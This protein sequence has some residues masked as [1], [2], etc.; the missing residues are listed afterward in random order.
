MK[1]LAVGERPK[2]I[3][4]DVGISDSQVY[5]F[6]SREDIKVLIEQEQMKLLA[7]LPML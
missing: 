1:R 2:S 5:R 4:K 7:A 3:A 6:A